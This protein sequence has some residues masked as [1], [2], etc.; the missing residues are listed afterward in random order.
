MARPRA[1]VRPSALSAAPFRAPPRDPLNSAEWDIFDPSRAARVQARQERVAGLLDARAL[2]AAVLRRPANLAWVTCGAD[3]CGG[4]GDPLAAVFL[5]RTSRV[6]VCTAADSP[7]LFDRE[8]PGLGF[9]LKQRPWDRPRGELLA[10]LCRGRAVG[11]DADGGGDGGGGGAADL[12]AA[13][14]SLRAV[15][16]GEER[17]ALAELGADVAHAVEAACRGA[18]GGRT[19]ADLVGEVAHRLYRRGVTSRPTPA[20]RA[21]TAFISTLDG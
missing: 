19:E 13:F 2:D 7:H 4:G 14:A 8:I 16:D 20:T 5:T 18:T 10:D 15:L 1:P 9:Q 17:A 6:L 11:T 3:L 21:G 12:S